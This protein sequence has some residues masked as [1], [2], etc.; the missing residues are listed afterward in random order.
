MFKAGCTEKIRAMK[1][2]NVYD[3]LAVQDGLLLRAST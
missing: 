2:I 1:Y 3:F